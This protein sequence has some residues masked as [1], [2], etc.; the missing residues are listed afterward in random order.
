MQINC[1]KMRIEN[2][3]KGKGKR[4]TVQRKII[5]NLINDNK[6]KHL[7]ADSIYLLARRKSR[8]INLSTVYRTLREFKEQNIINE[9]HLDT[10]HHYYQINT[11]D[12]HQHLVCRK[13]RKVIEFESPLIGKINKEIKSKYG[14]VVQK[15]DIDIAGL[16]RKCRS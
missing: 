11:Q 8:R 12:N 16:C 13:C 9:F 6:K 15:M 10:E 7:T 4:M 2:I 5:F 3:F 1:N 14:F